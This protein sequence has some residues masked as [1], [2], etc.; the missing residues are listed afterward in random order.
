L[1]KDMSKGSSTWCCYCKDQVHDGC[2]IRIEI[3]KE[4]A[5]GGFFW[6]FGGCINH[7]FFLNIYIA[8]NKN[9]KNN[10]KK[11][12]GRREGEGSSVCLSWT[13]RLHIYEFFDTSVNTY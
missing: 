7:F 11:K 4:S 9:N 3:G 12:K 6:F 2:W 10:S 13:R 1:F 8:Y 5:L